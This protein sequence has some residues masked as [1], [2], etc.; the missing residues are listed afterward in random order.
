MLKRLNGELIEPE[1][2]DFWL[3]T[4]GLDTWWRGSNYAQHDTPWN[5]FTRFNEQK[6][7]L[8]ITL[9][10]DQIVEVND[11]ET[12]RRFVRSGGKLKFW[13]GL[14]IKHGEKANENLQRAL[15]ERLPIVGY[16]A[17]PN[18][19]ALAKSKREIQHFFMG[20]AYEMKPVLALSGDELI[21]RLKIN[22]AFGNTRW[23][24][25][26]DVLDEG[27]L[28]ELLPL[29][30]S[31]PHVERASMLK[32]S[33][34]QNDGEET[35]D[36]PPAD[37]VD[38]PFSGDGDEPLSKVGYAR[39]ALPI[40]V[41]HVLKQRDNVMKTMTY[42]EVAGAI[43]RMNKHGVGHG[44]G[45]GHVLGQITEWLDALETPWPEEIPYLTTIVVDATGQNKGLPGIGI[46]GK[47][48]GYESL[49]RTDKESRVMGEHTKILNFGSRWIEVL[50]L[51]GIVP[52]SSPVTDPS[53]RKSG[54]WGGGESE[55]HRALKYFVAAHPELVGAALG[56]KSICEHTLHSDDVIDV[57][58]QTDSHWVGVEV[59]SCV[60]DGA[61]LDYRRGIY[62]VV[63]YRSV[64]EA[65]AKAEYPALN[66]DVKVYLVLETN[67]PIQF[68]AL[69]A[70]LGVTILENVAPY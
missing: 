61:E 10:C 7:T 22:E 40:L 16:E 41:E 9:W 21:K 32:S 67:L 51:L 42:G 25:K 69:A 58:F 57:F 3:R 13:R 23:G 5:D 4:T 34:L 20:R 48:G 65:Q 14:T 44:R 37:D 49:S 64:L 28:F 47:W 31:A 46:R 2:H 52:L 45:M 24:N 60:S 35:T 54:G 8:V 70:T 6:M 36:F 29:K 17:L 38:A 39:R 30:M 18:A 68:K 33:V 43:E 19:A 11:G 63:K 15:K 55:E 66:I 53:N 59:K 26:E 1:V 27:W 50:T 56:A 62:Q 12:R